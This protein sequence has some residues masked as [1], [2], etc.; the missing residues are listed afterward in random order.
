MPTVYQ[1][2]TENLAI[3][4]VYGGHDPN[5]YYLHEYFEKVP[6]VN[7]DIEKKTLES[8]GVTT[9]FADLNKANKSFE[10]EAVGASSACSFNQDETG[11]NLV[12]DSNAAGDNV[13]VLPHGDT[14]LSAWEN[15]YWKTSNQVHWSCAL[16]VN[17]IIDIIFWAGLKL[18]ST[19]TLATNDHQAYFTF[20]PT[21]RSG[22][23]AF[24]NTGHL[25]FVYSIG[26]TDYVTDLG[27]GVVANT[28]YKLRIEIDSNRQV[29]VYVNDT[30]YG[31][32]TTESSSGNTASNV[33]V[34]SL[35]LTDNII[36]KPYIGVETN[37]DVSKTLNLCYQHISKVIS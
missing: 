26:G 2:N 19:K 22:G 17:S 28:I 25:H 37:R 20:D 21:N 27:I 11:I 4:D 3:G 16:K 29:Q 24:T 30:L 6:S 5:R 31:L 9:L 7:G 10:F 14:N 36:L 15:I 18:T 35:A 33:L 32:S 34:K 1:Y 8:D 12:T 23:E 13:I